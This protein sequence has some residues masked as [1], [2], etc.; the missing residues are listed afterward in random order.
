[1]PLGTLLARTQA[2]LAPVQRGKT[3]QR[4]D[5]RDGLCALKTGRAV[6]V[7]SARAGA[8]ALAVVSD[9]CAL[10]VRASALTRVDARLTRAEPLRRVWGHVWCR[11][12]PHIGL[13]HATID[14]AVDF[15]VTDLAIETLV[16]IAT[17]SR[18]VTTLA[19]RAVTDQP[20]WAIEPG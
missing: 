7:G 19:S 16:V 12:R 13:A 4:R 11:R 6:T 17:D 3:L 20:I 14:A 8:E 15:L 2:P 18:R 1:M 10:V 5:V 9:Y